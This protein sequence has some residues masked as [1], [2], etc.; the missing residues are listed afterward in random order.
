MN[1]AP[2][3]LRLRSSETEARNVESYP[4]FTSVITALCSPE[5][6]LIIS[7]VFAAKILISE[8]P[9]TRYVPERSKS[10]DCTV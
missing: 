8:P 6:D 1:H 10:R 4:N 2:N 3:I 7:K 5:M 9:V